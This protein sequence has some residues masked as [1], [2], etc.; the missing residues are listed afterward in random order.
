MTVVEL[1]PSFYCLYL[2]NPKGEP[3]LY[4]HQDF[5][6]SVNRY[7][8]NLFEDEAT[9]YRWVREEQAIQ[10]L[11]QRW[12]QYRIYTRFYAKKMSSQDFQQLLKDR[13]DIESVT[14]MTKTGVQ[15]LY[16][17]DDS[18]AGYEAFLLSGQ[19]L[20]PTEPIYSIQRQRALDAQVVLQ[21][22][23]YF[24][25]YPYLATPLFS[26]EMREWAEELIERKPNQGYYVEQTTLLAIYRQAMLRKNPSALF[27]FA[28]E[29]GP[30]YVLRLTDL[31]KIIEDAP[32]Y[33]R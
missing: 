6:S 20:H 7:C 32:A 25:T 10:A 9:L 12:G 13:A 29:T 18:K 21:K 5:T 31:Q 8:L 3:Y 11:Q 33:W 4:L 14:F 28:C 23:A 2:T 1:F 16:F 24:I 26:W 19:P 15:K 27:V 17:G 30:H 22:E